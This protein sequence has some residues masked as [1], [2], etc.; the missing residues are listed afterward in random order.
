MDMSSWIGQNCRFAMPLNQPIE[1]RT[2]TL[3]GLSTQRPADPPAPASNESGLI[4]DIDSTNIPTRAV[5]Q[6]LSDDV[7]A[8][9]EIVG[10]AENPEFPSF[11]E[12]Y[13]RAFPGTSASQIS[14]MLTGLDSFLQDLANNPKFN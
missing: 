5:I 2:R 9:R 11:H 4:S 6:K 3:P 8:I 13:Q 1:P 14:Q 12:A 10:Y 7:G